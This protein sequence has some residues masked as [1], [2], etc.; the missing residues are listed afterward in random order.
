[1]NSSIRKPYERIDSLTGL[2]LST[3]DLIKFFLQRINLE[4]KSDSVEVITKGMK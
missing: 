2:F 3:G 1:M 4:L